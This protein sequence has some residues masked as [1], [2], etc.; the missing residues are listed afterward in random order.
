MTEN[1]RII[2]NIVATYGRSLFCLVCGIFT[3][4]W[5][6]MSLGEVDYGLYGVVGGL[7]AFIAFFNGV[8]ASAIGRF[9]AVSV[10]AMRT[11]TDKAV[12]L[13]ECRAWFNTAVSIHTVIPVVLVVIGYP[14]GV[15]AIRDFLTIPENRICDCIWLFR[16]VCLSCFVGMANVPFVAMYTAK[17]YIAELTVYSFVQTTVNVVFLYY[18]VSHP[19]DWLLKYGIWACLLSFVPQVVIMVRAVAVFPECRLE[20]RLMFQV[21]RFRQ[22]GAFAIWQMIGT[23]S[24]LLRGQGMAILINKFFGPS[25]NAAMSIGQT[26]N[27]QANSLSGAM[28][29]AFSPAITNAYGAGDMTRMRKLVFTMSKFGILLSMLFAIPLLLELPEVLRIWL[30]NPPAYACGFAGLYLLL[31]LME[32]ATVG[33]MIAINATGRIS[34]YQ[35][36]M[37]A[38]SLL[39]LPIAFILAVMGVCPYLAVYSIMITVAVYTVV[40]LLFARS[41]VALPLRTWACDI[42]FPTLVLFACVSAVGLLPRFFMP[43]SLGRIVVTT[44]ACELVFVPLTWLIVLSK[45]ERGILVEKLFS[46]FRKLGGI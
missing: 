7:A 11:S 2:L 6:L 25:V 46:R 12:A 13:R 16:F 10:G 5:V 18:M 9:Y 15:W 19:G 24:G 8:L 31:M 41:L 43:S 42:L 26:V 20:R 38:I 33:H 23:G 36:S 4:R 17:Q 14:I 28:M 44:I 40:R 21:D 37:G 27:S 30:K 1:R 3:G 35:V 34:R 45:Q 32:N 29:G 22:L 39:A